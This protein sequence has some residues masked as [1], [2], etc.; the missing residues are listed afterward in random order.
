MNRSELQAQWERYCK[1]SGF[2]PTDAQQ[3][4]AESLLN[5]MAKDR[6]VSC[7]YRARQ[8]GVTTLLKHFEVF[9]RTAQ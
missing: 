8:S 3:L 4:A 9:C 5:G 2:T 7:F 6:R 1:D